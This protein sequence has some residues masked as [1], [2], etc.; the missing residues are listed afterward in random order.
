MGRDAERED[1]LSLL[2]RTTSAW[3]RS[4]GPGGTG[5]TRL[6]L[7]IGAEL[8][9]ELDDGVWWVSLD[10]IRDPA[11]GGLGDRGRVRSARRRRAA[12]GRAE[13]ACAAAS[14]C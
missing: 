3:S 12:A 6:S 8:L 13:E 11:P 9:H 4:P 7:A 2:R 5:K 1:V 10:T 14:C